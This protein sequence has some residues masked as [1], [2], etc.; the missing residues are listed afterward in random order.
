MEFFNAQGMSPEPSPVGHRVK[1]AR[2]TP[3]AFVPGPG[4]PSETET[5]IHE[6][7]GIAWAVIAGKK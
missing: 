7:L 6:Y 5:A 1:K 4:H 2:L 3:G